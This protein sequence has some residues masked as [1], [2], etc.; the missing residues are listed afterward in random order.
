MKPPDVNY[1]D[2]DYT[3]EPANLESYAQHK[4]VF[5]AKDLVIRFG[6]GGIKNVGDGPARIIVES[7]GERPFADLH[8]LSQ[9]VDLR[10]VNKRVLECL[11]RAGVLD[12]LGERAALLAGFD[13]M[14]A[15]SQEVHRAKEVGQRSLFELAGPSTAYA[16]GSGFRL[17]TV[18]PWSEKKR[19]TDEKELLGVYV[20]SHPL[21]VL[22][23]YVD[24]RTV[25]L[26]NV[27]SESVGQNICV[28][29]IIA[30]SRT[31]ATKKGDSMAFAQLEDLSGT[32]EMVLF[33]RLYDEVK[34]L[35]EEG[36][37][38]LVQARVDQRDDEP[39]LIVESMEPYKLSENAAKRQS[40]RRKPKHMQIEVSLDRQEKETLQFIERILA[41]LNENRGDV[42][43]TL[44][45]RDRRGRVEM[46]FP[47]EATLYSPR[48][49]QQVVDLVGREHLHVEWA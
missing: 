44:A 41:L 9:R 30:A 27:D 11:V 37:L 34:A 3:I 1:S 7:R 26:S 22:A 28:A 48:L 40:A 46:A 38:V 47:N 18:A 35:L 39:K 8:D 16:Q 31:I 5:G 23:Q 33:P 43:Y 49:E 24:D 42:P 32:M 10:Q 45:L 21:D 19:L 17:P 12:S 20:S 36:A 14:I 25:P 15:A 13:Q 4:Q 6:L 2:V 29:G